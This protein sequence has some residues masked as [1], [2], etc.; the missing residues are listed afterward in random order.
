[1]IDK[2]AV[3]DMIA[4]SEAGESQ[5]SIAADYGID[6]RWVGDYVRGDRLP[7]VVVTRDW[8][9][10]AACIGEDPEYFE[11]EPGR[12]EEAADAEARYLL[13]KE[14]CSRCPVKSECLQTAEYS[15]RSWTTRGGLMPLELRRRLKGA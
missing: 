6:R 2:A 7:E 11:Y 13:A 14:V 8:M 9:E 3:E 12:D 15:D 5:R 10:S 4:R 1:M